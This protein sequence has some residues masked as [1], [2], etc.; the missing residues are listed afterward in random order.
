[1]WNVTFKIIHLGSKITERY[2]FVAGSKDK[3]VKWAKEMLRLIRIY[4]FKSHRP[5]TDTGPQRKETPSGLPPPPQ[6]SRER[7][8]IHYES[9]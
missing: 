5:T 4:I 6:S 9:S 3:R 1:M 2:F 8:F 7:E